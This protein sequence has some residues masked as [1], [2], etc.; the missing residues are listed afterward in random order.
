[1]I[2]N[3]NVSKNSSGG[4]TPYINSVIITT[5]R[6]GNTY[7][8]ENRD[9]I[10]TSGITNVKSISNGVEYD[11]YT[12][13]TSSGRDY[14]AYRPS[15]VEV[16]GSNLPDGLYELYLAQPDSGIPTKG[17][18]G[19]VKIRIENGVVTTINSIPSA[20]LR[21]IGSQSS[22]TTFL[23]LLKNMVYTPD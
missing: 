14:P 8:T 11:S 6:N 1:M 2:F 4:G 10:L 23:C 12:V 13:M 18:F 22:A 7:Y 9:Y 5:Y 20:P 21:I 19:G 16:L 17:V 3:T 15:K